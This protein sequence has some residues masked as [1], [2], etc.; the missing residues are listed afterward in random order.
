M[1]VWTWL[2]FAGSRL[3]VPRT[4]LCPQEQHI[5]QHV[6]ALLE[7]FR[8]FLVGETPQH[9]TQPFSTSVWPLSPGLS[10]WGPG[11]CLCPSHAHGI[12]EGSWH[13]RGPT[14][15]PQLSRDL[16]ANAAG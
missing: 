14:D 2:E 6:P 4:P 1:A 7:F 16:G 13:R 8:A 5:P 12:R 15:L 11:S 9:C 3:S 10:G